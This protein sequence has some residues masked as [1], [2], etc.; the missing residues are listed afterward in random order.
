VTNK[1]VLENLKHRPMRSLLSV[2]LIGV[3]VTLILCLVGLSTGMLEDSQKRARGVGADIL[4]R[5][6]NASSVVTFSG[7]T[8][9]EKMI[10]Y[11][12]KQIPHVT[13]ATGVNNHLVDFPVFVTGVDLPKFNQMSGGFTYVEGG[14][15]RDPDDV[16]VDRYYAAEKR[17]K[18]GDT[19]KLLN[20]DWHVVGIIEGGKL[21]R[22]VVPL[23][24]LQ[25]LD[26]VTGKLNQIYLKL[27]NPANTAAVVADIRK[28]VPDL[29][30]DTMEEITAAYNVSNFRG[31]R[32]FIWVIMGIGVVIGFF[33]VCLSMYMAVL[34]RTREIGILKSLGASK[35]F[36]L[37]IIVTE[38]IALG[39]GGTVVG[40]L[41]S[42]GAYHLIRVLVP[43]SIP[44]VIVASWWPKAGLVTLAGAVLGALYPGLSAA[45][46]DPIE[47][48]SYE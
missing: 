32:E 2:L 17:L 39:I 10:P 19:V 24:T 27:D 47:A 30:V 13:L 40:I 37:R 3:P 38:A 4:V 48:L 15:L 31:L 42:Y 26:S 28:K 16:L 46:Q 9:S 34:Q 5:G 29:K 36:I 45:R 43:S 11:F 21:A 8:I 20:H 1:L 44:M 12:E 33:V 7:A 14:P 25:E 23:P 18:V 22:I 35:G 6:S 41:L